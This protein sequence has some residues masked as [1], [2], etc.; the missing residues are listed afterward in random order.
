[1]TGKPE[2][3]KVK[4]FLYLIGSDGRELNETLSFTSATK[5]RTLE[6]VVKAFNDHCDPKKNETVERY[7][8]FTRVQEP[9]ES[10]EKFITELKILANTCNF[11]TLC[12]SL[13]RDCIIC[14]IRDSEL[15]ED[16]LKTA[17]LTLE[18]CI[19]AC[20]ASE[21]PKK[22]NKTI[23]KQEIVHALAKNVVKK[24]QASPNAGETK[25]STNCKY[26]GCTHARVKDHCPAFGKNV[27][28]APNYITSE[29]SV[30][31][32]NTIRPHK[33]FMQSLVLYKMN[34]ETVMNTMNYNRSA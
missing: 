21:L 14:G 10:I 1:M 16:L 17:E 28:I 22:R 13:V 32:T 9:S 30:C 15:R 26:C 31:L 18:K 12:D 27:I 2:A 20:R 25:V 4:L 7:K 5:N 29:P 33:L 8:F 11:E 6:E 23:E 24:P 3:F 34:V 19:Q